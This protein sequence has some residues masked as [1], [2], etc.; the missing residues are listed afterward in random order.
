MSNFKRE[1]GSIAIIAAMILVA[2]SILGYVMGS[3]QFRG[4]DII[5]EFNS[6]NSVG[7]QPTYLERSVDK[8]AWLGVTVAEQQYE[9]D[10]GCMASLDDNFTANISRTL[11]VPGWGQVEILFSTPVI[12]SFSYSITGSQNNDVQQLN[13]TVN[14][15]IAV[16][17]PSGMTPA[18][19]AG[20]IGG[21]FSVSPLSCS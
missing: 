10:T 17:C 4:M 13:C 14:C 5:S 16:T 3:I 11:N 2:V 19:C 9:F 6:V 1:Q 8:L 20:G 12:G 15:T 21:G 7:V 18:D